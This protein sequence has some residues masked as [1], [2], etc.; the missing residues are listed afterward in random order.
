MKSRSCGH[1]ALLIGALIGGSLAAAPARAQQAAAMPGDTTSAAKSVT[2]NLRNVP[3]QIALRTLFGRAGVRSYVI[4]PDVQGY[5]N[6]QVSDVPLTLA[7]RQ[8]LRSVQA[9]LDFTAGN[10]TYHVTL[11]QAAP[12]AQGSPPLAGTGSRP[13]RVALND[14]GD[15]G[16]DTGG[17]RG[18]NATGQSL[19]FYPVPVNRYDAYYIAALLGAQ[20]V[21]KV[22]VNGVLPSAFGTASGGQGGG[23]GGR[24]G[25]GGFGTGQNGF[26]GGQGGFGGGQGGGYGG[27]QGGG[28]GRRGGR[29]GGYG[30]G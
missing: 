16:R 29:G 4:D 23:Q 2:L 3:V 13:T 28:G 25:Q 30:G 19:R 8:L 12:S 7:L 17:A 5:A 15:A 1:A 24:G 20:G 27:G 6:V 9:P 10:G 18:V 22:D 26:G 11:R 14:G 21:V